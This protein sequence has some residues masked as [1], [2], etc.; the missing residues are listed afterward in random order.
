MRRLVM[1]IRFEYNL[2]PQFHPL[3]L[4]IFPTISLNPEKREIS[5]S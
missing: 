2:K 1:Y 5:A 3:H 4:R